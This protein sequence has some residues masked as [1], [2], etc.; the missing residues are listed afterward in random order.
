MRC[1][2][3]VV[4]SDLHAQL[5]RAVEA[6]EA[7]R[8]AEHLVPQYRNIL[9]P[10]RFVHPETKCW[11]PSLV[12]VEQRPKPDV[13]TALQAA[14]RESCGELLPDEVLRN[15]VAQ[16]EGDAW[17][18]VARL[19]S[20]V[21]TL[22]LAAHLDLYASLEGVLTA[23]L[24][25]LA[26]LRR[27]ALLLPGRLQ[28]V[29]KVQGIYLR[30]VRD[31]YEGCWHTDGSREDIVAVV[32]YYFRSSSIQ[33]GALEFIDKIVGDEDL[34][35]STWSTDGS[36]AQSAAHEQPHGHVPVGEG[37]LVVFSN[38]QVVHRVLRMV[39]AE[40]EGGATG[41]DQGLAGR[42]FV[43]F[44]VVDQRSPLPMASELSAAPLVD[45][46]TR[47]SLLAE[48]LRPSG[49]FGV[50]GSGV[51]SAGN[52][53]VAL[54]GWL[55]GRIADD[56]NAETEKRFSLGVRQ[57]E[58]LGTAPP[59]SRTLSWQVQ[60]LDIERERSFVRSHRRLF[61]EIASNYYLSQHI[62][63]RYV[64]NQ[65]EYAENVVRTS[66]IGLRP[67][68]MMAYEAALADGMEPVPPESEEAQPI[69][70]LIAVA[71]HLGLSKC[72]EVRLQYHPDDSAS[73]PDPEEFEEEAAALAR[74]EEIAHEQ[75]GT[76]AEQAGLRAMVEVV[77]IPWDDDA[78][79]SLRFRDVAGLEFER[80]G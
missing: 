8:P 66:A 45:Q 42:D 53:S 6:L 25:M 70:L 35:L 15:V 72:F 7:A 37:S 24:P 14:V 10:N 74:C 78:E 18:W 11:L 77:E 2:A 39:H 46:K 9:D 61:R 80:S 12:T 40:G 19:A 79:E 31:S 60:R 58:E 44:F 26:A 64:W 4:S 21:Q 65:E 52:G 1:A 38:Q 28:V 23:A 71:K 47:A 17:E 68:A 51:S 59:L 76:A 36:M 67:F 3:G 57:M 5:V 34:L 20:P 29:A 54:V 63:G 32:L 13:L 49:R 69:D 41:D 30:D 50:S 27:P 43:A 16:I 56:D 73:D 75:I 62:D 48:Q 55:H 22:G 33:G